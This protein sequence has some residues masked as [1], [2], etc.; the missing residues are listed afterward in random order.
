MRKS[1]IKAKLERNK[2]AL[3]VHLRLTDAFVF[4]LTGGDGFPRDLDRSGTRWVQRRN[5]RAV[6]ASCAGLCWV[7][8]VDYSILWLE[9]FLSNY[10]PKNAETMENI[11]RAAGSTRIHWTILVDA[12]R[13]SDCYSMKQMLSGEAGTRDYSVLIQNRKS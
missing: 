2:H 6:I 7:S 11:I 3:C 8:R 13:G 9:M 4:E 12:D 5:C 1:I 10:P